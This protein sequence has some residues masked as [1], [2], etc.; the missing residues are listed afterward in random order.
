[1]I[2]C[3]IIGICR[4]AIYFLTVEMIYM[5][6]I[7]GPIHQNVSRILHIETDACFIEKLWHCGHRDTFITEK[8]CF[9]FYVNQKNDKM[10][11]YLWELA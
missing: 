8:S 1:M 10:H 4:T 7:V 9:L 3:T 5:Q 11:F 2:R 6:T